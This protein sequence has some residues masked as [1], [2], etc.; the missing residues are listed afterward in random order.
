MITE[1]ARN[2]WAIALR[3]A[4]AVLFGLLAFFWPGLTIEVL[5]LMF[6]A[7]VVVDGAF[8]I[9][10]AL[11][12]RGERARWWALLFEGIA[13]IV[14]G[15]II[16]AWPGL[17]V[18]VLM[19]FI[20]AW[21]LITGLLEIFAAIRLREHI[22][23]EWRLAVSGALSILFAVLIAMWPLAGA[24]AVAWLIGAY[25]LLFGIVLLALAFRL[26]GLHQRAAAHGAA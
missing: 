11:R 5:I 3:G 23:G 2:W 17:T 15:L 10:A 14:A 26:R 12:A 19:Y 1:L 24:V 25:A 16:W 9:A 21:S 22:E 13:N 20:A 8:T 6:G 4:A 18:I 7:Y